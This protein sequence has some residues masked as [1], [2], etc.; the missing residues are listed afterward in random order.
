[1]EEPDPLRSVFEI[2]KY[3]K[4]L[5]FLTGAGISQEPSIPTFRDKKGYW[6][7]YDAMKLAS[8]EAFLENPALF[9]ECCLDGLRI[10]KSAKPK[11]DNIAI[12]EM[13]NHFNVTVIPQNIDNLH[14]E[15]IILERVKEWKNSMLLS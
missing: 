11:R 3:T 8:P 10:I 2:L 5:T 7:K 14:I 6:S 9:G 1:M 4:D 15:A 13:K 12:K